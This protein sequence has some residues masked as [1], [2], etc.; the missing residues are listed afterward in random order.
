MRRILLV[1]SLLAA[2][3]F[4]ACDPPPDCTPTGV[5][6][7][8]DVRYRTTPGVPARDQS[9]DLYLPV[10]PEACD[11]SPLVVY[12]HGGGFSTGDKGNQIAAKRD[13]FTGEGWA[14]ASL[15]YRL[16]DES[17]GAADG[18]YPAAE[19][20]VAAA[21][22]FLRGRAAFHRTDPERIMLLGHSAGAFL[23][24]L[25][26]TDERFLEGAGLGLGAVACTAPVDT[27]YD[28]PHEIAQGGRQAAM[29]RNAFG[30]DPAVW[31]QASPARNV[32]AGKGI[33][34]FHIITRGTTH[35]VSEAQAFATELDDAGVPTQIVV[36]RG[37]SHAEVND[38]IGAPGDTRIT[39]A[40]MAFFRSCG[41]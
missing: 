4:V 28:I 17:T 37:M 15:N 35:R 24:A 38:A 3:A 32:A 16:A 41:R 31:R 8:R 23:V 2:V 10:R 19:E 33:P 40:L 22:A 21:V 20:D 14:F 39:P 13:L 34:D 26:S 7:R 29:F 25:E 27:S 1:T 11:P 9:L 18:R 12:V 5:T 6:A 36:A 30:T